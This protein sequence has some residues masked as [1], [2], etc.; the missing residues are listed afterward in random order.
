MRSS[1]G[2]LGRRRLQPSLDVAQDDRVRHRAVVDGLAVHER[3]RVDESLVMD[4][5]D[6]LRMLGSD[7][8]EGGVAVQERRRITEAAFDLGADDCGDLLRR[9]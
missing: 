1:L 4:A 2:G 8:G 3:D 6:S 7:L 9:P 5:S